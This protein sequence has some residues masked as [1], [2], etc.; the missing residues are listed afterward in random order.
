MTHNVCVCF[1]AD[2]FLIL[3]VRYLSIYVKLAE[4]PNIAQ[5]VVRLATIR[6]TSRLDPSS[7][8]ASC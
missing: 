2:R 4:E 7:I 1:P 8:C 6:P 3:C 5:V